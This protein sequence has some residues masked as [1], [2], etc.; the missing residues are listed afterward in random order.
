MLSLTLFFVIL[1]AARPVPGRTPPAWLNIYFDFDPLVLLMTTLATRTIEAALLFAL[2]TCAVTMI[3]GRVFCGWLCPLGTVHAIAGRCFSKARRPR[4]SAP[5]SRYYLAKYVVLFAL[6]T[7]AILNVSWLALFD[8]LVLLYR[9]GS[10]AIWPLAQHV[11]ETGATAAYDADPGVGTWRLTTLT[12]PAYQFVRD[13]V[14]VKPH[15][16]FLGGEFVLAFFL[17]IVALNW[18]RPRFWCRYVCP[19]GALLGLLS[20]RTWLR[21]RNDSSKCNQCELCE[22]ACSGAACSDSGR[23][24]NPQ[25]CMVCL[26][27]TGVCPKKAVHF[28]FTWPW[29][30]HLAAESI[31]LGRRHLLGSAAAGLAGAAVLR[32]SP[33]IRGTTFSPALIRPPGARSEGDFLARC[34]ACGVCTKI[35]PTGGLQPALLD[36]GLAGLWTPQLV[37]RMGYC[38][39]E[40]NRCGHVC[41]TGAIEALPLID[42]KQI[43]IGLAAINRTR[44]LPYAYGRECLVCE[45]HCPVPDKAIFLT[46]ATVMTREGETVEIRLPQVDPARC[47]GCGA[48]ENVCPF[49]DG[50]AIRVSSAGES[51]HPGNQP[52]LD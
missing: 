9:S 47:T 36:A 38:D 19:L 11:V 10:I 3:F 2:I 18:V 24:W 13:H 17:L 28:E 23:T 6:V 35:C 26:N 27:C 25:E 8:P 52:I 1:L 33:Q 39:F 40:C 22:T 49:K 32:M 7:A 20:W 45:E 12:E 5:R 14:I 41:P 16:S 15:Q 31:D 29:R 44:C 34:I 30:R 37:P 50:P 42:K 4:Q 48:C 21:R 46:N 43:R 51:R